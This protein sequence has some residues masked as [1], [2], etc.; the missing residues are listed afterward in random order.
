MQQEIKDYTENALLPFWIKR[1]IDPQHGGFITHFDEFG[2][3]AGDDE[4]SLI[5]QTRSIF[6]YSQ[7][8]RHR[9]GGPIILEMAQNG[10][11]FL[12]DHMWDSN[13]GG[14]HW[15]VDRAGKPLNKQKIGYGH[16][17]PFTV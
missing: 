13:H 10:V 17:L 12:L 2:N 7:A 16:S 1:T 9:F 5:A 3:D 14:F 8:Y 6:T 15:M 11:K 4:K